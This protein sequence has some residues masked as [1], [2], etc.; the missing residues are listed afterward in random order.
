MNGGIFYIHMQL[1][2]NKTHII[3]CEKIT[4]Y[5]EREREREREKGRQRENRIHVKPS[6]MYIEFCQVI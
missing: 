2:L 3:K 5:L 6:Y 1:N 4:K